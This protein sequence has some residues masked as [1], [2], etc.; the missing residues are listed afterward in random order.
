MFTIF[1]N[2]LLKY[3]PF[4]NI[5]QDNLDIYLD[6]LCW[7]GFYGIFILTLAFTLVNIGVLRQTSHQ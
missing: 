6:E 5:Y 1:S 2:I 7:H 4:Y 3:L